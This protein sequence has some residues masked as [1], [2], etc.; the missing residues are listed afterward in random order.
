MTIH[1]HTRFKKQL[2]TAP[3]KIQAALYERLGSFQR[4]PFDSRLSNHALQGM[5]LG[6][7][8]IDVTGDWRA[9]YKVLSD[10]AFVFLFLGT[11]SQ[12]YR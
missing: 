1:F 10:D 11:H 8:S 4:D 7:R 3:T 6:Y 5:Y 2:Q 9:I 12:L